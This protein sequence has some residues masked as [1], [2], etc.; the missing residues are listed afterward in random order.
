MLNKSL[1]FDFVLLLASSSTTES[2]KYLTPCLL[3]STAL[4][5]S[6]TYSL[7]LDSARD[8]RY[9]VVCRDPPAK[10]SKTGF[11]SLDGST[12]TLNLNTL[13]SSG[14]SKSTALTSISLVCRN[15]V[16][17]SLSVT[18]NLAIVWPGLRASF[19]CTRTLF[20]AP[21][22]GPLSFKSITFIFI[23]KLVLSLN[24][25]PLSEHRRCQFQQ[26]R[27]WFNSEFL[28]Y[29]I[30]VQLAVKIEIDSTVMGKVQVRSF[31][32]IFEFIRVLINL[33]LNQS[34]RIKY[35]L[36]VIYVQDTYVKIQ[37]I[38][39][40]IYIVSY[41]FD[42]KKISHFSVNSTAI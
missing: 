42:A 8:L 26:A 21:N 30:R 28:A 9:R 41:D 38:L 5:M 36:I 16:L 29:F 7:S 19:A 18:F 10:C 12:I 15:F 17:T 22:S 2:K 24:G 27:H 3:G 39:K 6:I 40:L 14:L 34:I 4:T 33:V 1:G 35:R 20:A 31:E 11:L 25:L 32:Q 13:F 37:F 23:A